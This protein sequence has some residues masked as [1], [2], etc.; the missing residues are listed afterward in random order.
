ML[1]QTKESMVWIARVA[2]FAHPFGGAVDVGD[3]AAVPGALDGIPNMLRTARGRNW[4]GERS[5]SLD[6]H[7]D[8]AEVAAP[9]SVVQ[10]VADVAEWA[11]AARRQGHVFPTHWT[12]HVLALVL[13][14]CGI[15]R[16][17]V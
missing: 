6:G 11:T 13:M 3:S 10:A 2:G 15:T 5:R 14:S 12:G 1:T 9:E 17:L 8:W 7:T 16:D 4:V